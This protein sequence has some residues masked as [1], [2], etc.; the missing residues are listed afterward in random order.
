LLTFYE[1]AE[2]LDYINKLSPYC[3]KIVVVKQNKVLVLWNLLSGILFSG[4]PFQVLYFISNKFKMKMA[5][6]LATDQ[7]DIVHVYMLRMAEYAKDVDSPRILDLIDAM[8]LNLRKRILIEKFVPKLFFKQELKRIFT[9]ENQMIEK[10]DASILVSDN[11][12]NYFGLNKISAVPLGVDT[13]IYKR[14][15]ELPDNKTIIF[16]GNMGYYPNESAIIWFINNCFA[17]IRQAVP[18]VKLIIVELIRVR[19]LKV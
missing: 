14:Y 15:S 3:Q 18:A 9:Y 16:S 6:L 7:F 19:I 1:R 2:E 5:A 17:A 11:D 10:Y 4:L 8:Q 13:D 12:K